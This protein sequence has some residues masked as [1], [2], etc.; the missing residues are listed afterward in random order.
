MNRQRCEAII[1]KDR[2][3]IAPC[4]H[5]SYFP[6]VI[7][8]HEGAIITDEDGNEYIDFLSSASSLN[9]GGS[10][11]IVTAAIKKQLESYTQ[12]ILAYVYNGITVEY[13]ERLCKS[14][15]G[16]VKAKIAF[17]NCGS[18]ANDAAVKFSRA[19]TGRE[20][21]IV[22]KNGYHGN[23]YGAATMTTCSE[24]M[25]KNVGPLLPGIYDFPFYGV[26]KDDETVEEECLAEM[27]E[28]FKT[29]LPAD[30][31]AA[32]VIEPV[33][34]DGG[35][36]P[37]H[38]VFMKMLYE[39][40]KENGILFI[41][42]EVQQ[43]FYRTG[44]MFGIENYDIVP[45][46][47]IMG[48]AIG[49]GLTLGAFMAREEIMNCLPA[50]AHVFTLSGNAIACAAGVAAF[51]YY[52]TEEFQKIL[53]DNIV[54]LEEEAAAIVAKHSDVLAFVRSIGMSLGI[55]VR[56]TLED[57]SRVIDNDAVFKILFRAYEKGLI[58][59]NVNDGVLRV[60]PP[61]NITKEQ[62]KKGFAILDEAVTDYKEG[63]IGDEV[64]KYRAGW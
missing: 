23:T 35:I 19:Y 26:D 6:L 49:G 33:Q 59:I 30:T 16:G 42:E 46:G 25:H 2:E 37:A 14:Y 63:K 12:Y 34:G 29:Y 21:I 58:I 53:A 56:V 3:Y 43:G 57:G 28:A 50:P 10:D 31:V 13:A 20:N 39:I 41:S 61:L 1:S 17:G 55:G 15:P 5:L 52:Q 18:D 54:T 47:I 36:L 8:K 45:D 64:L 44:K 11:P 22:F 38:P 51:D 40:C 48:K 62:I 32:V 9:L 4:Q 24:N 7:A 60:Q 27:K